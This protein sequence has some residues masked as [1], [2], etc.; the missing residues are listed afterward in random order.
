MKICL[1]NS[2]QKI[3]AAAAI[4]TAGL[5]V[6]DYRNEFDLPHMHSEI[7]IVPAVSEISAPATNVANLIVYSVTSNTG[8]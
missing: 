2:Q 1:G 8:V 6:C 7:P 5:C 3:A 4:L